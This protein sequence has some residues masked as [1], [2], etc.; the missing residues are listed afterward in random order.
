MNFTYSFRLLVFLVCCSGPIY[1][2]W[3]N[4]GFENWN[5]LTPHIYD[6]SMS[7]IYSVQNPQ[8]GAADGWEVIYAVSGQP[9]QAPYFGI[10]KAEAANAFSGN[11]AMILHTWYHYGRTQI[12]SRSVPGARPQSINGYY[13]RQSEPG[14]AFNHGLGE[15]VIRDAA[16]NTIASGIILFS[17]TA[18]WTPFTIPLTYISTAMPDSMIISFTNSTSSNCTLGIC[19][20]LWLDEL[21][22]DFSTAYVDEEQRKQNGFAVSPNPVSDEMKLIF[23]KNDI[24]RVRIYDHRG[25]CIDQF[26]V[27][28][29]EWIQGT[30]HYEDGVYIVESS[31][32]DGA[33]SRTRVI[34]AGR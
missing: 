32:A 10:C 27:Q 7:Q 25:R 19:D 14:G 23:F 11:S 3:I 21:S 13:K 17:D 6:T 5:S 20:L 1:S 33:L 24:H 12:I 4:S 31:G 2:Q 15:V 26:N 18:D 29:K 8:H 34:K 28:G 30:G 22:V 16:Q 9:L